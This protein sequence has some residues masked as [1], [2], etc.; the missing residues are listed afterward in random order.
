MKI[1]IF[2]VLACCSTLAYAAEVV[3]APMNNYQAYTESVRAAHH[4]KSDQ[5][6]SKAGA[7][8][9][10]A[11]KCVSDICLALFADKIVTACDG[12]QGGGGQIA[13]ASP[14][15]PEK[16][17]FSEA[18]EFG[19]DIAR[20]TLPFVD[21]VMS[22]KERRESTASAER[23]N[24]GLYGAFTAI[25]AQT[26]GLGASGFGS[27]ERLG[28]AGYGALERTSTSGF[29]ALERGMVAGFT[30]PREPTYQTTINGND[31]TLFGSTSTRSYA[32]N[33][34]SGKGGDGGNS[35][36][37]GN[38]G[39]TATAGT[40]GPGGYNT[41]GYGAPSGSVPCNIQK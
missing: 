22:S 15:A 17:W 28:T 21:R 11:A 41:A 33:C 38:G 14:P 39:N 35:A 4:S 5:C 36:P 8:K 32:N 29:G 24:L 2:A 30:A 20:A 12:G 40:A 26:A 27:L 6:E 16:S 13:V 31:N 34:T 1:A 37:G 9:T 23:Q 10:M 25:N 18:K 19:L 7:L 3:L